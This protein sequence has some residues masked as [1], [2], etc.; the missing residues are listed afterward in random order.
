MAKSV[1]IKKKDTEIQ[2][3]KNG[4]LI[5][6]QGKKY[7]VSSYVNA[8]ETKTQNDCALINFGSGHKI[9]NQPIPRRIS[10]KALASWINRT[11]FHR[12]VIAKDITIIPKHAYSVDIHIQSGY[13][14]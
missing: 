12:G 10:K 3:L 2:R 8:L 7:L 4:D 11:H 9:C 5:Y 1:A 6:V 14:A 13:I